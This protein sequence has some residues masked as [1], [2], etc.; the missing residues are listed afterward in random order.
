MRFE[1]DGHEVFASTGSVNAG[2]DARSVV[3]V[4]GAALDHTVWVM[5][6][7]YFARKGLNV[8]ALDLPGHGRSA[9]EPLASIDALSEWLH[10]VLIAREIQQ[11]TIV[12][13]SMG[14]LIA[15]NFALKFPAY[16]NSL[17][18]LCTAIPMPVSR[19]MLDASLSHLDIANRMANTFSHSSKTGPA[20]SPGS[21]NL[22]AGQ[23]LMERASS[24]VLH[25]DFTACNEFDPSALKGRVMVQTLVVIGDEDQM[26]APQRSLDVAEKIPDAQVLRIP[27]CGHSMLSERPNQVLDALAEFI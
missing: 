23:R 20:A 24:G 21:W 14:S 6:A 11:A 18:L 1:V 13:H 8:L 12:G 10:Q 19:V 15:Y 7:R 4:H 25:A 26:T 17:V 22:G 3:F 16:L 9:G 2:P 5:I 27:N